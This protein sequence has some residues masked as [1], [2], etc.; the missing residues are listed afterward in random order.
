MSIAS[1]R[2]KVA[3][4]GLGGTITMTS[5]PA[6]GVVPA[7]TAEDLVAGVPGLDDMGIDLEVTTLRQVAGPS[8]SFDDLQALRDD[9]ARRG[10]GVDGVV[11]TQGTDTIEETAYLLDLLHSEQTP[12]VVTGAMRNP[13]MLGADGQANLLA[14][15]VTAAAPAA[16]GWGCLVV[17]NDEI[18]SAAAVRKLHTSS[19][20]TFRSPD[21]GPV[22]HI[23]EGIPR[24]HCGHSSRLTVPAR[25]HDDIRIPVHTVVFDDDAVLLDGG[26]D[27]VDGLIIAAMGAGHIPARLVPIV[28]KYTARVPVVLAS[29][30]YGGAVMRSTYGFAGSERDL[31]GRG[32]IPAGYLDRVKARILLTVLLCSGC[33]DRTLRQAFATAAGYCEADLWPW[34]TDTRQK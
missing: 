14:A 28:D 19:T 30:A 34:P 9:I 10:G 3:V 21:T 27:R 6:G 7:L 8:L 26:E 11:I 17:F 33:D 5:S 16:R 2:R 24:F 1:T 31:I 13:T 32:L 15:I 25:V 23:V 18:H 4:I 29:R 20:A 12:I 22:G